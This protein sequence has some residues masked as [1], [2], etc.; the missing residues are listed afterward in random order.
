[1]NW[2]SFLIMRHEVILLVITLTLL[3]AEI[4]LPKSRKE[5]IIHLGIFLFGIHTIVGFLPLAEGELFGGM[6]RTNGLIHLVK[7]ILN[8]VF[9]YCCYNLQ[10]GSAC[11]WLPIRRV[12]SSFCCFSHH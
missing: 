6:F 3:M 1:M 7:N 5:S 11:I 9:S 12:P 10:I 4:S 8:L 2:S